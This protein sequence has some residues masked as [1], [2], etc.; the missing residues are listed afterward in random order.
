MLSV[1]TF[2]LADVLGYMHRQ[3]RDCAIA[4][5]RTVFVADV[6]GV[7]EISRSGG[8]PMSVLVTANADFEIDRKLY[9]PCFISG[10]REIGKVLTSRQTATFPLATVMSMCVICA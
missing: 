6:D 2:D 8:S 10:V 4:T 3:N 5:R 1:H 7:V 9:P